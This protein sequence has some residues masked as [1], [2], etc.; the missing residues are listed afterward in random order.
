[1]PQP[2]PKLKNVRADQRLVTMGRAETRQGARGLI[3]AGVVFNGDV[4]VEKAGQPV[5]PGAQLAVKQRSRFVGR[6][7]EKLAGALDAFNLD[8]TGL[9][10]LDVGA[11]TG[12]FTDCLLQRGAERVYAVDVGRGQ[13]ADKLRND[14]RVVSMERTNARLGF[15]LPEPVALLVA[16]VSFISLRLVLP[17]VAGHVR[18]GGLLLV[19][20][21]PQFEAGR[22]RVGRRGV[23]S[24]PKV[25]AS[26]A[27]GFCVWAVNQEPPL[28]VIGVRASRLE[29]DKGNREFFVL[30]RKQ[31]QGAQVAENASE[32]W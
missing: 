6:G 28:Q 23:V 16:D 30:L 17:A 14:P 2:K 7:G 31:V 27:G 25:H 12:G 8:V 11:S 13:L 32:D 5:A 15:G 9:V 21:K 26:V 29:G 1:M 19:L 22:E 4:L 3:L 24:D 10:A 20:V 18:P